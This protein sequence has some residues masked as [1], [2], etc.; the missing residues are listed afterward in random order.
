MRS[1]HSWQRIFVQ[2]LTLY[3]SI[4]QDNKQTKDGRTMRHRWTCV[5][6]R[7]VG[8]NKQGKVARSLEYFTDF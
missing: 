8:T 5:H 3:E 4:V 2:Y 7:D 1:I 6:L